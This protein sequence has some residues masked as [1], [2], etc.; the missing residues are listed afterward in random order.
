MPPNFM[1]KPIDVHTHTSVILRWRLLQTVWPCCLR[2][3]SSYPS[4]VLRLFCRHRVRTCFQKG[5]HVLRCAAIATADVQGLRLLHQKPIMCRIRSG[6]PSAW[7]LALS[8]VSLRGRW[9][10]IIEDE[11]HNWPLQH[12]W[13]LEPFRLRVP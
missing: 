4:I 10:L 7:W 9:L 5:E 11:D 8:S 2:T 13:R 1:S 3:L 12:R 6:F